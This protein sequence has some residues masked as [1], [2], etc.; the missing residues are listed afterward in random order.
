MKLNRKLFLSAVLAADALISGVAFAGAPAKPTPAPVPAS[1]AKPAAAAPVAAPTGVV[2]VAEIGKGVSGT[3]IKDYADLI[4]RL[5]DNPDCYTFGTTADSARDLTAMTTL[6]KRNGVRMVKLSY[7]D[8]A[9][10]IEGL[11]KAKVQV[12]P[13]PYEVAAPYIKSGQMRPLVV[14]GSARIPEIK[15]VPTASE[16]MPGFVY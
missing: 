3:D 8:T 16:V 15:D 7:K 14:F 1:A 5:K 11:M 6:Q 9:A 13:V 10:E 12:I 4:S 2:L